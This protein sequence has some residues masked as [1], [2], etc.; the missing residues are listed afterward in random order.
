MKSGSVSDVALTVRQAA[1]FVGV[2]RD[3][4]YEAI[5]RGDLVDVAGEVKRV[6]LADVE[7]WLDTHRRGPA[8]RT[9]PDC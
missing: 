6:R 8:T 4:I 3:L 9:G 5:G 1:E 7:A 2:S